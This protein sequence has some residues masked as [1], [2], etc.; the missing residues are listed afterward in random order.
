[1]K[2]APR[3]SAI[4]LPQPPSKRQMAKISSITASNPNSPAASSIHDSFFGTYS[5]SLSLPFSLHYKTQCLITQ[6]YE[7]FTYS[8]VAVPSVSPDR[9]TWILLGFKVLPRHPMTSAFCCLV[10]SDVKGTP[11]WS[12]SQRGG[13]SPVLSKPL[14]KA[15]SPSETSCQGPKRSPHRSSEQRFLAVRE[16]QV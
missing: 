11:I 2:I 8:W 7:D 16:E 6:C 3:E 9:V 14:L 5:L 10:N 12:L 13:H 15:T 1:M 4:H